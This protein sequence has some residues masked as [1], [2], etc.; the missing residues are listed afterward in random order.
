MGAVQIAAV[1]A[2][3]DIAAGTVYRYFPSKTD[4]IGE[5][6]RRGRRA[7][8]DRH[9]GGGR[10]RARAVIGAGGAIAT[11]ARARAL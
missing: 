3:A 4:L 1:A 8:A 10:C 5:L 6:D 2:R 7:R 11:F 9:A